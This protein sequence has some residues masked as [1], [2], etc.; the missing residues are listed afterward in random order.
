MDVFIS[1]SGGQSKQVAE[2]LYHY[3]PLIINAIKPWLSS[4]DIEAGA[5]W[6]IDVADKLQ[7]SKAGII[8]L[9][10]TNLESIWIH[11]EAGA[12]AKTLENT[13]V[14]P[15]LLGIDPSN[16]KGPL[17]QFQAKRANEEDTLRLI[18]TLNTAL[19]DSGLKPEQ[20][21]EAFSVWWPKLSEKLEEIH[22]GEPTP[23]KRSTED[24]LEELLELARTQARSSSRTTEVPIFAALSVIR[25]IVDQDFGSSATVKLADD[26]NGIVVKVPSRGEYIFGWDGS[27]DNFEKIL[28]VLTLKDAPYLQ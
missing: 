21:V 9:T 8:C 6:A 24:M 11:F 17:T 14:C 5:R 12:L 15:Y 1:W 19:G 3:L 25:L 20:L 2:A 23:K 16:V 28:A 27:V 18:E 10:P 7:Q 26:N 4:A 22:E 13:F